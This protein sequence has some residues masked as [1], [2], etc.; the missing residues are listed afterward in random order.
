MITS[1]PDSAEVLQNRKRIVAVVDQ[2]ENRLGLLIHQ[3]GDTFAI[4]HLLAPF[5]RS[6][7]NWNGPK[8]VR[9]C[10]HIE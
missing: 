6:T 2:G 8:A 4:G 10:A 3:L 1:L 7:S 9:I 5:V